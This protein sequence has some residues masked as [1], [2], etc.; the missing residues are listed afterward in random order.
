MLL[1]E[2]FYFIFPL[3]W[4]E[5]EVSRT[6]WAGFE[7][8]VLNCWAVREE[9]MVEESV[10]R[11]NRNKLVGFFVVLT[12]FSALIEENYLVEFKVRG[13]RTLQ[14]FCNFLLTWRVCIKLCM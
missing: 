9:K 10:K 1:A 3:G 7:L 14:F 12:F 2:S 8:R 5:I 13:S 4:G 6:P 11:Y